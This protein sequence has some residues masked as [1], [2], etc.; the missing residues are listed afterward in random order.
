MREK[1]TL[2]IFNLHSASLIKVDPMMRDTEK[3]L[4]RMRWK[5][6]GSN[7]RKRD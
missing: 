7:G 4:E 1:R 6:D 3:A 5:N 2:L